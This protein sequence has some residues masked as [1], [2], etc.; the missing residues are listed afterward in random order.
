M[1]PGGSSSCYR[2]H[3]NL[4]GT[5][6][7]PGL[8][9]FSILGYLSNRVFV[10]P[11][12]FTEGAGP[13]LPWMEDFGEE[14]GQ[15]SWIRE[16][17]LRAD[18]VALWERYNQENGTNGF[19]TWENTYNCEVGPDGRFRRGHWQFAHDGENLIALDLKTL[20][21]IGHDAPQDLETRRRWEAKTPEAQFQRS[22]LEEECVAWLQRYLDYGK[23]TLVRTERPTVR[24]AR[25]EA[26]GGRETLFC[27]LY[28]FYPK[29]IYITWMKDG[30]DCILDTFMENFY[31]NLDGTY[32]TWLSIE[33]DPKE[34]DLYRCHVEHH[35]LPEPL[36]VAWEEP[37]DSHQSSD[38]STS[39]EYV[40][41]GTPVVIGT[42][43][44]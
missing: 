43:S 32:Y 22:Y 27:H 26:H 33:V 24:V 30:K 25:K 17:V 2:L 37:G 9:D 11:D 21:W 29:W 31:P 3:F 38:T 12:N 6:P 5:E 39:G 23:E 10:K 40:G 41:F 44:L 16:S 14:E 7:R 35:S 34:R 18:L 13:Q 1:V 15:L 19:H 20:T 28:G 36:D 42:P 4:W 8:P